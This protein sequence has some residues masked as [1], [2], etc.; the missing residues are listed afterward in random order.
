MNNTLN[1][2]H[3]SQRALSNMAK[4]AFPEGSF[5]LSITPSIFILTTKVELDCDEG[6]NDTVNFTY[7][8]HYNDAK[9]KITISNE[10]LRIDTNNFA[11]PHIAALELEYPL[12]VFY[13]NIDLENQ[14]QNKPKLPQL[15]FTNVISLITEISQGSTPSLRELARLINLIERI[16][17]FETILISENQ[18]EAHTFNELWK[19]AGFNSHLVTLESSA[20]NNFILTW[21]KNYDSAFRDH[22]V[23]SGSHELMNLITTL[24]PDFINEVSGIKENS[25]FSALESTYMHSLISSNSLESSVNVLQSMIDFINIKIKQQ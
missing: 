15:N 12:G 20:S 25:T 1:N 16:F 4:T 5:E 8:L 14:K 19:G 2:K 24:K 9:R 18:N 21:L 22:L 10:L 3:L 6:K 7:T 23:N 13:P 17:E 11:N